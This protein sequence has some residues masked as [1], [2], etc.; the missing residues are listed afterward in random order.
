M[1]ALP[2]PDQPAARTTADCTLVRVQD[3]F[4]ALDIV[5]C[6]TPQTGTLSASCRSRRCASTIRIVGWRASR[7]PKA[8]LRLMAWMYMPDRISDLISPPGGGAHVM[9]YSDGRRWLLLPE[10]LR[11]QLGS[12]LPTSLL[13]A[14]SLCLQRRCL[15]TCMLYPAF[16]PP[17]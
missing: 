9:G 10:E 13:L 6:A 14:C 2:R 4:P 5:R 7:E 15:C 12:T 11:S 16:P 3:V 1:P 8:S 17:L